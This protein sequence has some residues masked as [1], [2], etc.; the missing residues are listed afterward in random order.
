MGEA[1]FQ[2]LKDAIIAM[3]LISGY[4]ADCEAEF[5]GTQKEI[6]RISKIVENGKYYQNG[7]FGLCKSE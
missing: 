7:F 6:D 4:D 3:Y 1:T 2:T 5:T